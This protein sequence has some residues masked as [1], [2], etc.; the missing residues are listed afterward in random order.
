M[1][2]YLIIAGADSRDYGVYIS[3][4]GT[5]SAPE[6]AYEFYSVPGRNGAIIGNENRLENI[7][8]SYE[9]FIYSNFD[10]NISEFRT[11]LLSL[12][13]YQT[14]S[15]SYHPKEYRYAVY[16]GPF[17]PE[18][19]PKNDAGAFTLTFN[20]KPQRYLTSG[21]Y[22]FKYTG[23]SGSEFRGESIFAYYPAIRNNW[24]YA[25][26]NGTSDGSKID[27]FT[28]YQDDTEILTAQLDVN[29]PGP[30]FDAYVANF[31]TNLRSSPYRLTIYSKL[32]KWVRHSA[33]MQTVAS[34]DKVAFSIRTY[35]Y[36]SLLSLFNSAANGMRIWKN[37]IRVIGPYG[38]TSPFGSAQALIDYLWSLSAD[39]SWGVYNDYIYIVD[40]NNADLTASEFET[41]FKENYYFMVDLASYEYIDIDEPAFIFVDDYTQFLIT[42]KVDYT[43][44]PVIQTT[45][46]SGSPYSASMYNPTP[47]PSNPLLKVYGT[48]SFVMDG[49]TITVANSSDHV[50]IDCELMDCY[51]GNVNRNNDVSFSTYDFPKLRPGE[52]KISGIAGITSIEITPRWWKV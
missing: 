42:G 16:V 41:Y 51:E 23:N 9:C 5:F 22:V 48:G 4:Q 21:D 47:F 50:I 20:C 43:T 15:D 11:F 31:I 13:G 45:Y 52:H 3:G 37:H 26:F 35:S 10:K 49:I 17:E 28:V 34:G 38:T 32:I 39:E 8:V 6:K 18:V 33:N 29:S 27:S 24:F 7:E 19:T 36:S 2:N 25:S 46:S 30:P 44:N 12:N 40:K 1:R 14:L